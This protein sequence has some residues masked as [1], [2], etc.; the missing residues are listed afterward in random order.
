M[1]WA[2]LALDKLPFSAR[3]IREAHKVLL[4]GVRG[5]K[6]QPGEFRTSQNWIGGATINDAVFVPPVHTTVPELMSDIEKFLHNEEIHFPEL[7]K[8]G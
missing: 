1:E 2:V 8:I 3:L 4:Q 7:L 5:E 6:K